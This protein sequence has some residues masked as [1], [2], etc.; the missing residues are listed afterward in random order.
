MCPPLLPRTSTIRASRQHLRV[1]V[2]V[3]V[4]PSLAHH[5][6]QV[7]VAD[8][9][10][11]EL[12]HQLAPAGH[13]VQ[14]AQP[15]LVAERDHHG[16][17]GLTVRR[18]DGQLDRLARRPGQQRP[19]PGRGVQRLAVHREQRV[20]DADLGPGRG[21]RRARSRIRGVAGHDPAHSPGTVVAALQVGAEQADPVRAGRAVRPV[22]ADVRMRRAE[23]AEGLPEQVGEVAAARDP[24]QQ[25]P[26][27]RQHPV[28]VHPGHIRD[29]EVMPDDP[30]RLR[31]RAPPQRR[32]VGLEPGPG[33]VHPDPVVA[34]AG[35]VLVL[36]R[37][38]GEVIGIPDH[39]PPAVPAHLEPVGLA[40]HLGAL[41][42]AEVE[43]LER[44]PRRLVIALR[45]TLTQVAGQRLAQPGQ[46]GPDRAQRGVAG[47]RHR[48]RHDPGRQPGQ[49][50]H[51]R[52]RG[53]RRPY[54]P[55]RLRRAGAG[56]P[57]CRRPRRRH[58]CRGRAA[59]P[60]PAGRRAMAS[61]LPAV[62]GTGGTRTGT[63][64][65]GRAHH[66]PGRSCAGRETPGTA[67]PS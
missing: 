44:G 53:Q 13:P 17:P 46:P 10:L 52:G 57:G 11:A 31:V 39:Q 7:Q 3:E 25:R 65:Q 21:Q 34:V 2:T 1:Q 30:A 45:A 19:G 60:R 37:H 48:H 42:A 18:G 29:P 38:H 35:V 43:A 15:P 33:Q 54:W 22:G 40:G 23:L 14:V 67:R 16:A 64:G 24:V 47:L 49:I 4:G 6:R 5:V 20:A 55:R 8:P 12:A 62:S 50:H 27:V 9:A 59:C 63:T 36:G 41:A 32:R 28:P 66:R 61:P 58:R 56:R 26:V 51:Y